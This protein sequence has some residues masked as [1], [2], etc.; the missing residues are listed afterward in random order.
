MA[1]LLSLEGVQ[2][3]DLD[4]GAEVFAALFSPVLMHGA[5][6]S[7]DQVHSSG[8][9]GDPPREWSTM[10]VSSRGPRRRRS[11]WCHR[12]LIN[13]Q[14]PNPRKTGRVI[15]FGLQ[16]RLDVG[17]H[18]VPRGCQLSGQERWWL[19]RSATVGSPSGSPGRPDAPWGRTSA[20]HVPGMSPSGRCVRG[21]SSV[22]CA[23]GSAPGSRP[24]ARRSPPPPYDRGLERSPHNQGSQPAGCTTQHRAPEHLGCEPRSSDGSP[25]NRRADH[26]DHNDQATQS[27]RQGETPPEVL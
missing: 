23:I 4:T 7:W 6:P 5:R 20:R 14:H 22:V 10:P 19:L 13:P 1:F 15:R 2:C 24:R 17:P 3:R 16:T 26:T 12:P 18:G 8:P 9:W 25:P 27:S 11:W 21:I